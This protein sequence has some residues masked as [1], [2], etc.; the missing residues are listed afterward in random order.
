MNP[1]KLINVNGDFSLIQPAARRFGWIILSVFLLAGYLLLNFASPGMLSSNFILYVLQPALWLTVA[2]LALGLW[3]IEGERVN[4]LE[5]SSLIFA[6]AT[7]G[8]TQVAVSVLA[9]LL[10]GFGHSPYAH[11]M[12]MAALNLWFVATSL[13]GIETARWYLGKTIGRIHAGLGYAVA[14]LLPLVLLIPFSKFS[15]LALPESAARLT[16]QTLLPAAAENLLAAFLVISGGP[17]ASI[18]YRG[19][20]LAF[21]WLSPIL[22]DLPWMGA[23][24]VGVLVPVFGLL[25]LNRQETRSSEPVEATDKKKSEA[26]AST[27]YWLLVGVLAVGVIWLNTGALGVRPSLV[28]GNSMNP[29]LYPGDVVISRVIPPEKVQVGDIIR[30]QRDRIDIVHRVV[31]VQQNGSE[32][33]FTTRGDNNNTNDE[34][35]H[36]EAM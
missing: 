19:V 10:A 27:G 3:S 20:M 30:Y 14:W 32:L 24:F 23:A 16:G 28:S 9:G 11:T 21:E 2:L 34:P 6:A 5:H 25:A 26:G 33:V 31:A 15:L 22:P 7:I 18:A 4:L 1:I 12:V 35:V 29:T 36:G 17:L 8:A 13:L